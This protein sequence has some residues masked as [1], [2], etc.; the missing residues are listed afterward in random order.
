MKKN[1]LD[2]QSTEQLIS[3]VEKLQAGSK[4]L[5]GSMTATEMLLHCN[6]IHQLLLSPGTRSQQKTSFRQYLVR[7]LVLYVLPNFPKNAKAPQQVR[8]KGT[9]AN[10][11]FEEQKQAYISLMQRLHQHNAPILHRHPYF[12]NL[13]T[14]QWGLASWKHADHHLRQFGV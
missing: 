7:G 14:A 8:T 10:E 12:G 4:A 6:K 1:V 9:V 13:S 2:Q 3:R 11:A 5:W